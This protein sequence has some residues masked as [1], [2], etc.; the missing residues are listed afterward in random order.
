M[1]LQS[2]HP[3]IEGDYRVS[4]WM[5]F[6]LLLNESELL[7]LFKEIE[8]QHLLCLSHVGIYEDLYLSKQNYLNL[9]AK[10]L[11]L[12]QKDTILESREIIKKLNVAIAYDFQ[13]F[14]KIPLP[15]DK[16]LIKMKSPSIQIKPFH[17]VYNHELEK[18]LP[19]VCSSSTI[20]FGL[21]ISFPQIFQDP[22]TFVIKH[23]FKDQKLKSAQ[24]F[25]K[26]RSFVRDHTQ[27]AR[28]QIKD[29]VKVATF[30]IGKK[31]INF[32]KSCPALKK[33]GLLIAGE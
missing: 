21:E 26:I 28:F 32:A 20:Y 23:I 33:E 19:N 16:I 24:Q 8:V 7:E 18:F 4:K 9:Y 12:L 29:N 30:R 27:P 22:K 11:E 5:N 14:Y 3:K 10:Y 6:Q 31:C 15:D 25:K 1:H 17:F 2:S 13:D